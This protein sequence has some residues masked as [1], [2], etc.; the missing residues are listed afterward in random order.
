MGYRTD[1]RD[2]SLNMLETSGQLS[3][4]LNK[5]VGNYIEKLRDKNTKL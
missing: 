4:T 1:G 3:L 2:S 5:K